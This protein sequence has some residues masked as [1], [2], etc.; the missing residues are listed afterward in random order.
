MCISAGDNF[1]GEG[2]PPL[3]AASLLVP[4]TKRTRDI[5]A[6]EIGGL[7]RAGEISLKLIFPLD[8]QSTRACLDFRQDAESVP[9]RVAGWGR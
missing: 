9:A 3:D 2:R 7:R 1:P 4:V 6:I 5:L 8:F